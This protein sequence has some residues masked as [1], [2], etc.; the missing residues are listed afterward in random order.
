MRRLLAAVP[1]A[2]C[3]ALPATAARADHLCVP[4]T[5]LCT[6]FADFCVHLGG[7]P[8]QEPTLCVH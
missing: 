5:V 8:W 7:D 4:G 6:D 1:L 3:L 2:L